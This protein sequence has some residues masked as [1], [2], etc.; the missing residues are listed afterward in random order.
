MEPPTS[1]QQEERGC[2]FSIHK[3]D[4]GQE[5]TPTEENGTSCGKQQKMEPKAELIQKDGNM[6]QKDGKK[7]EG[8]W[9]NK[10]KKR[11]PNRQTVTL[12]GS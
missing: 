12:G 8:G 3:E 6:V 5:K 10:K 2:K 9:N 1:I 4:Q 11:G 7:R